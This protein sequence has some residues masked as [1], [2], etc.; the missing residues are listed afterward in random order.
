[1]MRFPIYGKKNGN[2]TTNQI[3]NDKYSGT[4]LPATAIPARFASVAQRVRA[5]ALAVQRVRGDPAV[6]HTGLRNTGWR[7]GVRRGQ[8]SEIQGTPWRFHGDLLGFIWICWDFLLD[9]LGLFM[10]F[11]GFCWDFIEISWF[12]GILW[13]TM[14]LNTFFFVGFHGI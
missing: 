12:S 2:Q 11:V 3:N 4:L 8:L 9:F 10:G 14:G 7:E 1:M 13:D 5:R 6:R